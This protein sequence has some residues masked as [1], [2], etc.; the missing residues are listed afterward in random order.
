[1]HDIFIPGHH[2]EGRIFKQVLSQFDAPA[3]VRRARRIDEAF[4][5]LLAH[6][7]RQREQ[8]LKPVRY[9]LRL[10]EKL[11]GGWDALAHLLRDPEQVEALSKLSRAAMPP[12]GTPMRGGRSGR[13][14]DRAL[15]ELNE[16]VCTFNRKWTH[17]LEHLDL[18]PVN[19]AREGYNRYYVLEK[20]CAVRSVQVARQGFKPM[21]AL[22]RS[23]LQKLFPCLPFIELRG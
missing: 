10:L 9:R 17:F 21:P 5:S 16:S 4:Q 18:R 23:E 15:A 11:A 1:V 14:L 22:A 3:Y 19:E 6:C 20:E 13:T 8:A 7:R 2:D 12:T